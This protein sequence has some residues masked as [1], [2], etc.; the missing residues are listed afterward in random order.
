MLYDTTPNQVYAGQQIVFMLNPG[1]IFKKLPK[2]NDPFYY[3]KIGKELTD[4]EGLID[5]KTRLVDNLI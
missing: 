3:L 1:S 4:W 5:C 2:D